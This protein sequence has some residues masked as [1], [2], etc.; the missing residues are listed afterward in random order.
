[1][2]VTV[3][4]PQAASVAAAIQNILTVSKRG[5]RLCPVR[6]V[7]D[8]VGDKWSLLAILHLGSAEAVRFNELRKQIDGISQ[9][10]LTVTLRSL[11]AD[12]LVTR[13]AYAEVPPRVE[14]RLTALGQSLLGAVI[15]LGNWATAH[16]PAIAQARQA[17]AG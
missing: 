17:F 10:M 5:P 16:A 8:R 14:Y 7:L 3:V 12:G 9:R 1:M 2:D 13:T 4:D 15:A 11:E 6:D